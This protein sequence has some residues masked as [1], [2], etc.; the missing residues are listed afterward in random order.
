MTSRFTLT[1]DFT[2]FRPVERVDQL[3]APTWNR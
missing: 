1:S 2:R 3:A